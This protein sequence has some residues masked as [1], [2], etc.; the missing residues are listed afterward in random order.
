[1]QGYIMWEREGEEENWGITI[2]IA[3]RDMP[4]DPSRQFVSHQ[5]NEFN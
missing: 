5:L 4:S 2:S 1:M 3:I